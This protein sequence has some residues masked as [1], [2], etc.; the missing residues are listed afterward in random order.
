MKASAASSSAT[1]AAPRGVAMR[2]SS[3]SDRSSSW[4]VGT[5]VE[6]C[7]AAASSLLCLS[8]RVVGDGCAAAFQVRRPASSSRRAQGVP[9]GLPA[10]S[11]HLEQPREQREAQQP[12]E[13]PEQLG[14]ERAARESVP[15]AVGKAGA[16]AWAVCA[17]GLGSNPQRVCSSRPAP[18]THPSSPPPPAPAPLVGNHR[19]DGGDG[20]DRGV[21]GDLWGGQKSG[22]RA[23]ETQA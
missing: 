14:L 9:A 12:G 15:A 1:V 6:G 16:R 22:G 19:L 5:R 13:V 21:T 4:R 2:S 8:A 7:M 23:Q 10:G 11:S 17:C 3:D 20:E 18:S